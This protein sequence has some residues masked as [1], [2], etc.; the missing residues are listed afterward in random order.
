MANGTAA[1]TLRAATPSAITP[2]AVTSR[3][4]ASAPA[5]A[6]ASAAASASASAVTAAVAAAATVAAVTPVLLVL[7]VVLLVLLM[8]LVLL[9]LLVFA[10]SRPTSASA[11][12]SAVAAMTA[13]VV[14][15]VAGHAVHNPAIVTAS[16]P[17]EVQHGCWAGG[18]QAFARS[19]IVGRGTRAT[20]HHHTLRRR[21]VQPRPPSRALGAERRWV[22][23][24]DEAALGAREADVHAAPV[25][26][27]A[28]GAPCIGAHGAEHDDLLLPALEAVHGVDLHLLQRAILRQ[29]LTDQS[30]LRSV[31]RNDA[32][33]FR[34]QRLQPASTMA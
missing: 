25:R 14:V 17:I 30:H 15:V 33:V 20:P 4:L 6:S 32:A 28:H 9:V 21:P 3:T 7:L 13:V 2:T 16:I 5:S 18:A 29:V 12:A 34:L 19:L 10:A 1:Q 31:R 23:Q 22:S 8:L 24:H 27:E 26:E 11:V